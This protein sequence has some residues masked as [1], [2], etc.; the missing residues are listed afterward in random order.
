MAQPPKPPR[1]PKQSGSFGYF[2]GMVISLVCITLSLHLLL[3]YFN[4]VPSEVRSANE[5]VLEK[6]YA[7]ETVSYE[8]PVVKR[9]KLPATSSQS[10][11]RATGT[12]PAHIEIPK[13]NLSET[14]YSP[15]ETS[16]PVLDAALKKG[17]VHYPGSG[18]LG[19]DRTVFLFG[20]SSSLSVVYNKAYQSFNGIR[21]LTLG[22]EIKVSNSKGSTYVYEVTT[23]EVAQA[24]EALVEFETGTP[25]LVLSTCNSFGT[26]EERIVVEAV[27]DRVEE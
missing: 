9:R 12:V 13:V 18:R 1:P 16:I 2:I 17:V 19:Q 22:D 6:I 23:V 4:F 20:H 21:E 11:V 8:R 27:L 3:S 24:D 25:R 10:V 15:D 14:I 5:N 7:L 26:K